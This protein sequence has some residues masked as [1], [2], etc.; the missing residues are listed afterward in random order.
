MFAMKPDAYS[1]QPDSGNS[2]K[3]RIKALLL[4]QNKNL[5][6]NELHEVLEEVGFYQQELEKKSQDLT[7][8]VKEL[9]CL[10]GL[11]LLIEKPDITVE[12]L[13]QSLVELVPASWQYPK[14]TS[15]RII[16]NGKAFTTANFKETP[17]KQS[18]PVLINSEVKATFDIYLLEEKP[19]RDEGPFLK[20]ERSLLDALAKNLGHYLERKKLEKALRES[21]ENQRVTLQSLGDAVI[22]AGTNGQVIRM[23]PVAEELTGWKFSEAENKPIDEVFRIVNATTGQKVENPVKRVLETGQIVGLANHTKLIS[24]NG[25]EYQIADSGAPIKDAQGVVAGVVL[26]FRDVTE[27]YN[28]QKELKENEERFRVIVEGAPDPIF[29]QSDMKFAYLNP[30]ACRLFGIKSA[31]ELLGKPVME[32]FHP[33]YHERIRQRIHSLNEKRKPVHQLLELKLI[34][35]DGREVWGE[36]TGE[37]IFYEGR[38]GALVF[39]RDI[40][41]RKKFEEELEHSH[42]LMRYIIEHANSGVAVH[43]K[44]LRYV[45]V[46]QRY[47]EQYKVKDRNV[48]GRH[49]YD[50]FPDLPQ[51][52]REVHQRVLKGEVL[53]ADRD[54]FYRDDG[55]LEWTSWHCLPW[56]NLAGEIDGLIVYTEVITD[57]VKAEQE[58]KEKIEE[59]EKFN[60]AMVGRE[61]RMIELKQEINELLVKSG[62]PKKYRIQDDSEES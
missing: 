17:W 59:L 1:N 42:E 14:I 20:E 35:V 12:E 21:E 10:Y 41:G 47:L 56:Y 29:I 3:D 30:A 27:E 5:P 48:I 16:Y 13:M 23:N 18:A 50:V 32:R 53:S 58:L 37:P 4:Q 36:T 46:S 7:E 34:R 22:A 62:Q 26:V 9:N 54:S 40:A 31:D 60:R 61:N 11:S 52:W 28:I 19:D 49:H 43:D 6:E 25:K 33:D 38:E 8:R 55:S 57:R 15:A 45:Y 51:K 2:L 24:K 39:V 44:D